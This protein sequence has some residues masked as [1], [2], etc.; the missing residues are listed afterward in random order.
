MEM[1]SI[2][3]ET[4][5]LPAFDRLDGSIKA[6]VLIVGGGLCGLLC[7]HMLAQAGVD[8]VLIEADRICHG[9]SAKT[10]AKITSQHGLIYDVLLRRFG[11]ENAHLYW[12]ANEA[13]LSRYRSLC[14]E[15]DC[16]FVEQDSY[17]YSLNRPDR[18]EK[19]LSALQRIGIP[20]SSAQKLPLPFPTA[21]AV[22]FSRQAQFHPLQFAAHIAQGLNIREHTTA[23]AYDGRSIVTDGGRITAKRI[24]VATHFPMFNKHGSYFLKLYQ[25][26]SYVLALKNAA[27]IDG[28]YVDEDSAGLSFRQAEDMLLLGGGAHRTGRHGG[29]W[30]EL[31]N[32]AARHFPDARLAARWATQDCMTLD[33]MPYIGPY[34]KNTPHLFAATGF[35]KWGMT[36]SMLSAMILCDLVQ[37]RENPYAPLF[38]PSRSILRP[39]LAINALESSLHLLK[40]T[41]PRC[42]HMGCA[43]SWNAQEHSWD[44]PCHGSRFTQ[45]GKLLNNPATGDLP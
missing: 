20:A 2:W 5:D 27:K 9:V 8:Y 37:E 36:S 38:S 13:A 39:Q 25:H 29:G 42:P 18:I 45:N 35:N 23:R 26:R 22:C 31:E 21:G 30:A 11:A 43:L 28:M 24:I 12:E 44:C 32:F 3:M 41:R 7:A 34:S 33:S 19:E 6:D 4:A 14:A 16:G 17:V 40:P 10:T 1:N 15:I